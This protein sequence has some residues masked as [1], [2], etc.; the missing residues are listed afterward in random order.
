MGRDVLHNERECG[1]TD[2]HFCSG[3]LQCVPVKGADAWL[4]VNLLYY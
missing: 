4:K 2:A 3:G 1:Q